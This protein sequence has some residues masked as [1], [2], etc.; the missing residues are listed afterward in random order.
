[1][2]PM[3]VDVLSEAVE[4]VRKQLEQSQELVRDDVEEVID[5]YDTLADVWRRFVRDHQ[6]G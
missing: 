1:M 6:P 3:N 5:D 4:R 2:K